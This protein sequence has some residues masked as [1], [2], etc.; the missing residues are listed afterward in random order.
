MKQRTI[1]KLAGELGVRTD[2]IRYYERIGLL[3]EPVRTPSNYRLYDEGA[4][5]RL[6]FIKSGQRLGLRLDEI[7]ELLDIR[8]DGLCPCGHT[9]VLIR[10]RIAA[11]DE[12]LTRLSELRSELGQMIERWP[13]DEDDPA[14]KWHCAGE[15]MPIP[16]G[17]AG[18]L[19]RDPKDCMPESQTNVGKTNVGKTN[20]GKTN[21]G[22]TNVGKTNVGKTNVGKTNGGKANGR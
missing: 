8:D 15:I 3:P 16:D 21:V 22:K 19:C 20:V 9:S 17:L 2:T 7:R 5:E 12:E 11:V 14:G 1:S 18:W 13:G 10:N 4:A 6:R